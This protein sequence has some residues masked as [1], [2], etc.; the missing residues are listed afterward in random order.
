MLSIFA[1]TLRAAT[2]YDSHTSTQLHQRR[3]RPMTTWETERAE[4]ER[5]RAALKSAGLW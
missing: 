3:A 5:R 1:G 2:R 4:A